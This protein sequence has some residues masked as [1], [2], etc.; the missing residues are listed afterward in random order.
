MKFF[1]KSSTLKVSALAIACTIGFMSCSD[2][3][4]NTTTVPA[5]K[6]I[7]GVALGD[8]SF[9]T[10]TAALTK[11][12]LVT[13][14]QGTGPFT[15][16]APNNAAFSKAKI[17]SLDGLTKEALTPI[18]T[19]HVLSGKVMAADVKSGSSGTVNT[20]NNIYLTKNSSGVFINGN[21]K[22]SSAD[23]PASNGVIHVIDN[24]IQ[25]PT[26]NIVQ[27]ATAAGSF[28]ELL[29]LATSA[30]LAGALSA[31]SAKGL[32]VLAPTDAAFA[33]LYKTTPK[34]TL[35]LASNKALLTSVLQAHV[36]GDS[37]VFSSDLPNVGSADVATLNSTA[38][39][40]FDL[41]SGAKVSVN[42]KVN[43]NITG[44]DILTTNGVVH[45]ID[46]VLVP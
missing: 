29:E 11:A 25:P 32:T 27:A 28:K 24:V 15:V 10:L 38:K 14:L 22:V 5:A 40:K 30:G 6:D 33:E 39:L 19:S 37:R 44:T 7:V 9:S 45:V 41:S 16:F 4:D 18:L 34:A 13:T 35:L 1:Q 46:K 3:D 8:A 26:Q 23:V 36:I 20:N 42:G 12:D 31:A 17:T 21:I 2:D 43:A